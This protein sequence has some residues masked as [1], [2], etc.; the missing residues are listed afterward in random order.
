MDLL[1]E[2]DFGAMTGVPIK[3]IVQ[4][5][6]PENLLKTETI[7]YFLSAEGAEAF[8]DLLTRGKK[9]I[10]K[11]QELYKE[12]KGETSV[13]L[14]THG[15]LG[16]MLYAA[17]YNL[18]WV[19]VLKQFHFGNSEVLLLSEFSSPDEAHVF[20]INQYNA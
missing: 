18:D 9:A 6:A 8:P 11:I 14:V 19:D 7:N 2:R 4:R 17:Y 1:I 3:E 12:E 13:L 15:D 5:C 10:D 16:K 20:K